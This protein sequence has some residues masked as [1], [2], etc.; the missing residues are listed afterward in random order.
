MCFIF[1]GT[2]LIRILK[3]SLSLQ[4]LN[5]PDLIMPVSPAPKEIMHCQ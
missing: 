1:Y 2:D 5:I 3:Y 4:A